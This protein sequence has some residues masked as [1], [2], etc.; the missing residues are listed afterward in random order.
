MALD[1]FPQD[2]NEWVEFLSNQELPALAGSIKR[3]NQVAADSETARVNELAKVILQEPSMTSKVLR[4][5]NSALYAQGSTPVTTIS[6]GI[7]LLGF[8]TIRDIC[9]SVK[10]VDG[11]LGR[12][13]NVHLMETL[14]K[15]FHSATQAKNLMRNVR[16]GDQEEIFIAGLLMRMGETSIWSMGGEVVRQLESKLKE[17]VSQNEAAEA[18]LGVRFDHLSFGLAKSWKLGELLQDALRKP[19]TPKRYTEAVIIG[20]DLANYLPE[21]WDSPRVS[22]ILKRIE[23]FT[24]RSADDVKAMVISSAKDARATARSYGADR[25]V[26]L[27]P[28]MDGSVDEPE[29]EEVSIQRAVRGDAELQSRILSELSQF[30]SNKSNINLVMSTVV[31][32]IHRG[33]GLDRVALAL[34]TP[35]RSALRIKHVLGDQKNE[36]HGGERFNIQLVPENLFS[37]VI[38]S[39]RAV[40]AGDSS[41][42]SL[43]YLSTPVI[44][45][46]SQYGEFFVA[47]I[48][49]KGKCIGIFYADQRPTNTVLKSSQF[50]AFSRFAEKA[51][52]TLTRMT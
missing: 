17:G 26:K 10:I 21:G 33:I 15:S 24:G 47:P 28:I 12:N 30:E 23:S 32:G 51:G 18:V 11:L 31:E 22:K 35:D 27:I 41:S 36:W 13:P 52:E 40:W 34:C 39:G 6:R 4:I 48:L 49:V 20:D 43:N 7:V 2:L 9:I 37:Y 46:I 19:Q 50:N 16:A 44:Q 8:S 38:K 1:G 14:A 3:L 42:K 29:R 45:T 25:L 5:A